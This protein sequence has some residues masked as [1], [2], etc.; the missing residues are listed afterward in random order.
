M[1][2]RHQAAHDRE[3]RAERGAREELV[4]QAAQ[5]AVRRRRVARRD[6]LAR[7]ARLVRAQHAVAPLVRRALERPVPRGAGGVRR[8]APRAVR[9]EP[10]LRVEVA[11]ARLERRGE[12]RGEEGVQLERGLADEARRE[13]VHRAR[14]EVDGVQEL[15]EERDVVL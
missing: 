13:R 4:L 7:P 15:A 5:D 6:G 12:V 9:A 14:L 2:Y 3:P 11:Q 8:D 10:V 1:P